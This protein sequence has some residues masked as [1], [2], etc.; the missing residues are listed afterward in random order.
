MIVFPSMYTALAGCT[1]R[2]DACSIRR[3]KIKVGRNR[4]TICLGVFEDFE[5]AHCGFSMFPSV[6]MDG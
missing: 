6:M 3:V 5:G 1:P 4:D 2:V